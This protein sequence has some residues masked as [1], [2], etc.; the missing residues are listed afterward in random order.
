VCLPFN[1]KTPRYAKHRKLIA[2]LNAR[3]EPVNADLFSAKTVGPIEDGLGCL[4]VAV[5][6][7]R[8]E[9]QSTPFGVMIGVP[10]TNLRGWHLF[11]PVSEVMAA[12]HPSEQI[13]V[14]DLAFAK[15]KRRM[16]DSEKE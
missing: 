6:P 15:L 7:H 14:P 3:L 13:E 12:Y 1:N 10:Y 9:P 16:N 11:V 2:A 4:I 8:R 5:K